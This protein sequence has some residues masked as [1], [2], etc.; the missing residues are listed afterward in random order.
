LKV[1]RGIFLGC[2][3]VGFAALFFALSPPRHLM[4]GQKEDRAIETEED[5][6]VEG[7]RFS[8]W[9]E[10]RR[11]WSMDAERT[12]YHHTEKKASLEEVEVTF[13]PSGG[14]TM[15]L[16]AKVVD[17]DLQTRELTARDSVRGKSD[18]GY[19]FATESLLYRGTEREVVTDDQVTLEKDRL[20]IQGKGMQGSLADHKFRLLSNVRAAFV[21]Q[22]TLP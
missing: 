6:L 15:R 2:I 19:D 18:Q 22:G 17:Y 5:I 1:V 7:L 12:L 20:T 11:V 13:Y 8:E 21:P 4:E 10:G 3:I 9:Q 16:W 14:G